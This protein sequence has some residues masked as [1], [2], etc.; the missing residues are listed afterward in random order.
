[1]TVGSNAPTVTA[2]LVDF[3]DDQYADV[4]PTTLKIVR[5]HFQDRPAWIVTFHGVDLI[6]T[7]NPRQPG[8][9]PINHELNVVIDAATSA[10]LEMYSF[11]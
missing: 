6:G 7:G 10:Y 1:V 5:Y 8:A 4:D 2:R 3:S 9:G 11:R